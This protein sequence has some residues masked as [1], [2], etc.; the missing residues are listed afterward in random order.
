M[1]V[2]KIDGVLATRSRV[3][4]LGRRPHRAAL[5][6][7]NLLS[8][9]PRL[10]PGVVLWQ[11][12]TIKR[13]SAASSS[14]WRH[15]YRKRVSNRV[16]AIA[17]MQSKGSN[18]CWKN[19]KARIAW[20]GRKSSKLGR[21]AES[22]QWSRV[23]ILRG[24]LERRSTTSL[25]TGSGGLIAESGWL[26]VGSGMLIAGS[27]GFRRPARGLAMRRGTC[28][29]GSWAWWALYSRIKSS[30]KIS[31]SLVQRSACALYPS[32]RIRYWVRPR[33]VTR[34]SRMRVTSHSGGK[35]SRSVLTGPGS[36]GRGRL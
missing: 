8:A 16:L 12:A 33:A 5:I 2:V 27:G 29:W 3:I 6:L 34:L 22:S 9:L 10:S 13:K 4:Y 14:A 7:S 1:I 35:S 28:R 26:I 32:H 11:I 15:R 21:Y 24:L 18:V 36:V 30:A 23:L 17:C 20:C 19:R 31:S 25:I